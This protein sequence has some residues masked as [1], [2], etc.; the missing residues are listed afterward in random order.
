MM[1]GTSPLNVW[2]GVAL[3]TLGIV[4]FLFRDVIA[5]REVSSSHRHRTD[6]RAANVRL[7]LIVSIVFVLAGA[8]LISLT[9]LNQ[10]V[11]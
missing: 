5:E 2:V 3:I 4:Q 8:L 9:V 1:I 10:T 6:A 7:C 11:F